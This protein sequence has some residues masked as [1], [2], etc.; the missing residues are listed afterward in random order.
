MET[1]KY[2]AY[3][4]SRRRFLGIEVAAVDTTVAS[5]RKLVDSLFAHT[6]TGLWLTPYRGIPPA[7]GLAPFDLVCVDEN[8]RL[9]DQ[10]RSVSTSNLAPMKAGAT[11][12]LVLPA[13]T[14]QASQTQPDD[15]LAICL[16]AEME[17][18]LEGLLGAAAATAITQGTEF[19]SEGF[20]F[21]DDSAA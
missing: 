17:H 6:E 3:N 13:G 11:S 9:I 16:P 7:A 8:Y 15:E 10:A 1:Q 18:C 4:L 21:D 2:C 19:R 14:I 5:L 12:A 20:Q